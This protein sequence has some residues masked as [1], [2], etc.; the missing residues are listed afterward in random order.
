MSS[1]LLGKLAS[2]F[3]CYK[4]IPSIMQKVKE[5]LHVCTCAKKAYF[6][7][8]CDNFC[9][10][11]FLVVVLQGRMAN[12]CS[13]SVIHVSLLLSHVVDCYSYV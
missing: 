9:D 8:Y 1:S 13:L 4:H 11:L 6:Q 12:V 5:C 3:L 10:D 2:P 7:M